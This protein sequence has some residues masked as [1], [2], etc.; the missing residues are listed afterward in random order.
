M[1]SIQFE[2]DLSMTIQRHKWSNN[3]KLGKRIAHT[4]YLHADYANLLP[5]KVQEVIALG[6][7]FYVRRCN[8]LKLTMGKNEA[9]KFISF[10]YCPDFIISDEPEIKYAV[11]FNPKTNEYSKREYTQNPPV[12]HGKWAF[13]PEHSTM[14]DIQASYDR[15]IWINKQLQKFG[16]AK[17]S[18]GWK[19]Q[20]NGILTHLHNNV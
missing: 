14:F 12:Y 17:R 13:V 19:I 6:N 1:N 5:D 7:G 3:I 2:G 20:W 15:T 10:I 9:V 8:V 4:I 16:I 11:K 18:I